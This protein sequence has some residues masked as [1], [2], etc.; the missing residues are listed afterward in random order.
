MGPEMP[1]NRAKLAAC[2]AK[3]IL[4]FAFLYAVRKII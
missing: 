3:I 2:M 1:V 4:F